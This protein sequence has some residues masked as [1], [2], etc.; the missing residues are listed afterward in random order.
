L[1]QFPLYF[2]C[3]LWLG[4]HHHQSRAAFPHHYN[5]HCV[6]PKPPSS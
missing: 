4:C 3:N 5:E 2:S 6:R 1:L